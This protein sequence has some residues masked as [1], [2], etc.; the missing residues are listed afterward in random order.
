MQIHQALSLTLAISAVA[1]NAAPASRRSD[2]RDLASRAVAGTVPVTDIA[3]RGFAPSTSSAPVVARGIA[4]ISNLRRK[5]DDHYAHLDHAKREQALV[6]DLHRRGLLDELIKALSNLIM[7][8]L[9]TAKP[10]LKRQVPDTAAVDQAIQQITCILDS[11]FGNEDPTCANLTGAASH[12]ANST[13][14]A[15]ANSTESLLSNSTLANATSAVSTVKEPTAF[16]KTMHKIGSE[17]RNGSSITKIVDDLRH[18][19]DEKAS[20]SKHASKDKRDLA[21]RQ[22]EGVL[23]LLNALREVLDTLLNTLLPE[24]RDNHPKPPGPPAR[25]PFPPSFCPP[26]TPNDGQYRPG[27]P[28]YGRRDLLLRRSSMQALG[29]R[30]ADIL[31]AIMPM[32]QMLMTQ[33]PAFIA[34]FSDSSSAANS[35]SGDASSSAPASSDSVL[36]RIID[37]YNSG[38]DTSSADSSADTSGASAAYATGNDASDAARKAARLSQVQARSLFKAD[39]LDLG[40]AK[41]KRA[42][43]TGDGSDNCTASGNSGGLNVSLLDDLLNGLFKSFGRRDLSGVSQE[44]VRRMYISEHEKRQAAT[45]AATDDDGNDGSGNCSASNNSGGLNVSLLNNILNGLLGGRFSRRGLDAEGSGNSA[46]S[47]ND[48]GL[49]IAVLNNLLNG[50]LS[51][52]G[53][54]STDAEGSFNSAASGNDGGLNV[55]AVDN[56]LNGVFSRRG[57]G[58]GSAEGSFNSAADGNDGGLNVAALDNV[59]NGVFSRRAGTGYTPNLPGFQSA[60]GSGNSAATGNDGGLNVAVAN[61]LLNGVLSRRDGESQSEYLARRADFKPVWEALRDI[62]NQQFGSK[63]ASAA[64]HKR[65]TDEGPDFSPVWDAFRDLVDSGYA[66]A[67]AKEGSSAQRRDMPTLDYKPLVQASAQYAS[68]VFQSF[69]NQHGSGAKHAKRST[70]FAPLLNAANKF[71]GDAMKEF[72]AAHKH[73]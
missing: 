4:K 41:V 35:T 52:R 50:L 37:A 48:G 21:K 1:V 62:G 72:V 39:G 45:P 43:T 65:S 47:G 40:M 64:S 73:H 2:V 26:P 3:A 14:S 28:G 63:T 70:D 31:S 17:I 5:I 13:S 69:A 7:T 34:S 60:E 25:P 42:N 12:S 29:E 38:S 54:G 8:L 9:G 10:F 19:D 6:H 68:Q 57:G 56:L 32:V 58:G 23:G 36:S 27:C 18:P 59:L 15:A 49:N 71:A 16:V 22:Q 24:S 51:R 30:D 46:A 66:A 11:L 20:S 44:H 53:G 61:N 67:A 55:A 33:L